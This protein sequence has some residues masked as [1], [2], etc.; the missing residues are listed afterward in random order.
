MNKKVFFVLIHPSFLVLHPSE[1]VTR[2]HH[3]LVGG[4]RPGRRGDGPGSVAARRRRRQGAVTRPRLPAG[5]D[6]ARGLALRAGP[7]D[8]SEPCTQQVFEQ[9]KPRKQGGR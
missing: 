4:P 9:S 7:G 5:V 3:A 2:R 8:L 6:R 1:E